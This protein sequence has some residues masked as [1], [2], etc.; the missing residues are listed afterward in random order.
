MHPRHSSP[1]SLSSTLLPLT[2]QAFHFSE[3]DLKEEITQS[4][5]SKER[6]GE[7]PSFSQSIGIRT[8]HSGHLFEVVT[9]WYSFNF[10]SSIGSNGER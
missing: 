9:I 1:V 7:I 4:S 2:L 5:R 6:G 10:V 8:T 3:V